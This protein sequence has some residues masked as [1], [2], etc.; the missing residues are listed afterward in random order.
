MANLKE[1]LKSQGINLDQIK[2]DISWADLIKV[3]CLMIKTILSNNEICYLG[4]K[5]RKYKGQS[6]ER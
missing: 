1:L 5:S 4:Q 3:G 6:L 2:S